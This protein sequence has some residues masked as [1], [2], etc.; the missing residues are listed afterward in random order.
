MPRRRPCALQGRPL[1]HLRAGN[2]CPPPSDGE[3]AEPDPFLCAIYSDGEL[4]VSNGGADGTISGVFTRTQA[5][6][7]REYF[8]HAG[9]LLELA[10]PEPAGE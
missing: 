3:P 7:L 8:L 10:Q 4:T 2:R 1:I 9:S 5:I 6:A